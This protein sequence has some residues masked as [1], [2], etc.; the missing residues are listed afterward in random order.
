MGYFVIDNNMKKVYIC[1]LIDRASAA[2]QELIDE[3][4]APFI[5]RK[6]MGQGKE[7]IMV[8][9][10]LLSLDEDEDSIL[11]ARNNDVPVFYTTAQ[12]IEYFSDLENQ[13]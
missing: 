3:G 1:A 2:A 5:P 9:D 7:W 11:T 13:E 6:W 10:A 12:L 8:C 4:F